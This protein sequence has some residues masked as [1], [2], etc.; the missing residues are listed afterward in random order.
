MVIIIDL[1]ILRMKSFFGRKKMLN[2]LAQGDVQV[3]LKV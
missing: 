1:K 2:S 3:I